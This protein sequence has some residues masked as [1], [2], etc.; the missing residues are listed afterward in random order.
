MRGSRV[1]RPRPWMRSSTSLLSSTPPFPLPP[2]DHGTRFAF[3]SREGLNIFF[4]R[5]F[6]PTI[7]YSVLDR[8]GR[9]SSGGAGGG[10]KPPATTVCLSRTSLRVTPTTAPPRRL[11]SLQRSPIHKRFLVGCSSPFM[12]LDPTPH[13]SLRAWLY[14]MSSWSA[15]N[16]ICSVPALY[17]C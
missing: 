2:A 11:S 6:T 5:L 1:L 14:A 16:P 8:E 12:R 13:A 17:G 3:L 15:K 4:P 7:P 10:G 9:Q